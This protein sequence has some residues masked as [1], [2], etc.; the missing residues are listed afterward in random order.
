MELSELF[1]ALGD[2]AAG[3]RSLS[4]VCKDMA[5]KD[6]EKFQK[7][8]DAGKIFLQTLTNNVK[9]EV[10]NEVKKEDMQ[11]NYDMSAAV[12]VNIN[13]KQAYMGAKP[14]EKQSWWE[15]FRQNTARSFHNMADVLSGKKT[16]KEGIKDE[17]SGIHKSMMNEV[18]PY[19]KVVSA[20]RGGAKGVQK[21]L[22]ELRGIRKKETT[23]ENPYEKLSPERFSVALKTAYMNIIR[24]EH[25]GAALPPEE[26]KKAMDEL[27]KVLSAAQKRM[28]DVKADAGGSYFTDDKLKSV[29]GQ[30]FAY[31]KSDVEKG[32]SSSDKIDVKKFE[33]WRQGE[34]WKLPLGNGKVLQEQPY[35]NSSVFLSR[36]DDKSGTKYNTHDFLYN[37]LKSAKNILSQ[38]EIQ[39]EIQ[40]IK[41]LKMSR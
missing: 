19:R 21:T 25:M 28:P 2:V 40:K 30:M 33:A 18:K 12:T 31:M 24:M 36:G 16:I 13:G 29:E 17:M 10:K 38:E 20:S 39:A 35:H 27:Q 5:E 23:V 32:Q 14:K 3:K 34:N 22:D 41:E 9:N 1:Y 8:F 26:K 6:K 37:P 15:K 11:A 4:D 7:L